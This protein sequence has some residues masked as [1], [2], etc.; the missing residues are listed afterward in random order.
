MSTE[1]TTEDKLFIIDSKIRFLNETIY[2]Y[3]LDLQMFALEQGVDPDREPVQNIAQY[4]DNALAKLAFLEAEK[5]QL[6]SNS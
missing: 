5:Q 3:D 4:K 1:L 2:N 6:L